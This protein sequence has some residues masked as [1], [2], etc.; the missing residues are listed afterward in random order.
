MRDD[1]PRV[2]PEAIQALG[3]R[4]MAALG[5]PDPIAAE[6]AAHLV[7]ADLMGV[8]SHG[9]M[10]LA[11][12]ADWADQ[13]HFKPAGR[14]SITLAPGG[15]VVIDGGD[16]FGIPAMRLAVETAI[17][18]ARTGPGVS[19]VGLRNCGHTG[20]LGAFAERAAA[21]GCLAILIGGGAG[22]QWPQVVPF[23]GA[24]GRLPTNPYAIG[25]PGGDNGPVILDFATAAGAGGKIYAAHYAGRPLPEGLIV[26]AAGNPSTDPADYDVGGALLPMAG[27]KGYAMALIAELIGGALLGEARSGMNWIAVAVDLTGFQAPDTYRALAEDLL[28]HIRTCPPAPGHHR[29][30]IPGERERRIAAERAVNGIPMPQ[31]TLAAIRA[32]AERLG[33]STTEIDEI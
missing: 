3:T 17:E 30:E 14:S 12:Y 28:A 26:D 1:D 20:R 21:E 29:V 6:V 2:R 16:G 7:A 13:G 25:L 10:R 11:Q 22:R 15:R 8:Y 9:C 5:T 32:T 19:V 24:E 27:P 31:G 4:M 18:E 33:V 23:G